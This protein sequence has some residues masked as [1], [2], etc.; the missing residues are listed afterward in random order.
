MTGIRALWNDYSRDMADARARIARGS[1]VLHTPRGVIEYAAVGGGPQTILISHGA[2]GG[3]DQ[4]LD[5]AGSFVRG[6]GTG[7]R[8]VAPSRFGYLRSSLPEDASPEAQ[9]DAYACLLDALNIHRI[10][11]LGVSAGGPSAMQFALRH[12]ARTSA[13]LLLV[14]LAYPAGAQQRHSGAVPDRLPLTTRWV[15]D[16]ALSSDFLFWSALR[17]APSMMT[18]SLLG[19]L[20]QTLERASQEE[21]ARVNVV[22]DHLL[23]VTA[24]RLGLLNDAAVGATL[25]RYELERITAPALVVGVADC[26][27]GTYPGARH[28]AE[29][30][31][32][33]R[34]VSIPDGGHLWAGHHREVTSEIERFL[35]RNASLALAS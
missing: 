7:M 1:A 14:P 16:A 6:A 32:G 34:F 28:S 3:F 21:Q 18:R 4:G 26:L 19:T 30:I 13:L 10:V 12:P 29:H 35:S 22:R 27:Y 31:P 20:P 23:P 15:F 11:M 8:V 33:A 24:R 2:G 17:F 5:A 25:R 9:A